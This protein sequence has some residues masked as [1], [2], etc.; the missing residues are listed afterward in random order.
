MS[1]TPSAL[2]SAV[3]DD[4][5]HLSMGLQ[6]LDSIPPDVSVQQFQ[7]LSL[8]KGLLKKVPPFDQDIADE[9]SRKDFTSANN[10]CE[11]WSKDG[12]N[13]SDHLL[14]NELKVELDHFFH[15]RG[16]VLVD[17]YF[18]LLKRGRTGPGSA[19]GASQQSFYAKLFSSKMAV[20]STSLYRLYRSYIEWFPD[21]QDAESIRYG[22]FGFPRVTNCSRS[23]FVPKTSSKSR[24]ICVEP[25]LNVLF[26]LGLGALM[27]DRL[28]SAFNVD[29]TTQPVI[30][31]S[32]AKQ[33]SIDGSFGTIDLSSASDLISVNL[34]REILPSWL[35]SMLMD[36]RC[37]F[38]DFGQGPVKL[39]MISTMG[40]GFTFPL[41]TIIFSCLIRSVYRGLNITPRDS[42]DRNWGCFGD[43]LI[44]LSEAGSRV[45]KLLQLCGFK[46]N[47]SKSFLEGPFRES[48]GADWFSGQ[49]CRPVYIRRWGTTQDTLVA[50]NLLNEWSARTGIML[51]H[52]VQYLLSCLPGKVEN[53]FVPYGEN[54]DAGLRVPLSV[55]RKYRCR[56]DKNL[57]MLYRRFESI[58]KRITFGDG[59]IRYPKGVRRNLIYNPPGLLMSFLLGELVSCS[60]TIRHDNV[61]YRSKLGRSPY[62]D[63][64]DKSRPFDGLGLEWTQWETTV[65]TNLKA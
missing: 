22:K 4:V 46:V 45:L 16:R 57:T 58:P 48:C 32:L 26:Q 40:N 21:F 6:S 19:I 33:G 24:M 28:V 44:C 35:F 20:T 42:G 1:F 62:W 47:E 2:Y 36:L 34:C 56:F 7:S 51:M 17:S 50:I 8:V 39:H 65:W 3:L 61:R 11:I 27:T 38:T 25:S 31:R 54:N 12:W 18:D 5:G 29:L 63:F 23:S 15:P 55:V 59:V 49:Y 30:N 52:S 64:V 53:Y 14:F 37:E 13:E 10:R 9:S 43:D 41:Q 60:I